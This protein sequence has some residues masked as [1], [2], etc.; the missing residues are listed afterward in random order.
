MI[1]LAGLWWWNSICKIIQLDPFVDT[2]LLFVQRCHVSS[3]C[4][5]FDCLWLLQ[6]KAHL[7]SKSKESVWSTTARIFSF[8]PLPVCGLQ[9]VSVVASRVG[10]GFW[11][12]RLPMTS[13]DPA[14]AS[15][16]PVLIL[17]RDYFQVTSPLLCF[18]FPNERKLMKDWHAVR[19]SSTDFIHSS[20][21]LS[22]CASKLPW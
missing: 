10:G 7:L 21:G 20:D 16:N 17:W 2:W 3:T 11:N 12:W 5:V 18:F 4:W 19:I 15:T 1:L 22:T 8:I 6:N 14:A 9:N 13:G